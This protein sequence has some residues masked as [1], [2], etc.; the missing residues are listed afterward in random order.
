MTPQC[1]V[2]SATDRGAQ[3][4][5]NESSALRRSDENQ[6]LPPKNPSRKTWFFLG[7][8]YKKDLKGSGN[9]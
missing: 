6:V 2:R 8:A 7:R 3:Q 4:S 9:E 5:R 1:G